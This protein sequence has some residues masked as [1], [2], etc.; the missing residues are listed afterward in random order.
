MLPLKNPPNRVELAD[1]DGDGWLDA[2][3][4]S[5]GESDSQLIYGPLWDT[6]GKLLVNQTDTAKPD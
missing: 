5:R 4:A 2:V 6:F 1:V 3:V